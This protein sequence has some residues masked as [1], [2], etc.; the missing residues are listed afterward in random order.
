MS[1]WDRKLKS[2]LAF[3][4]RLI[5]SALELRPVIHEL[6]NYGT[7]T[8]N[9]KFMKLISGHNNVSHFYSRI[10]SIVSRIYL[11]TYFVFKFFLIKLE[12]VFSISDKLVRDFC[13][14]Q[15]F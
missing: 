3:E 2:N 8:T 7:S 6:V 13:A 12:I 4:N 1:V 11:R 5:K 9:C 15:N 14:Q 10:R